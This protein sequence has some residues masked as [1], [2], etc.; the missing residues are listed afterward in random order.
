P[1]L[2]ASNTTVTENEDA[3][4]MTC[5]TDENSINWLFNATSLRLRERM[6]LSQD[7]TTL[8]IV[9]VRREDVGNYQCKV[10]NPVS[11]TEIAPVE[12]DVKY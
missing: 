12:L 6:K 5:Y 1:T 7:H 2:L 3:V 4:V 11:S 8:T 9:P 10:S